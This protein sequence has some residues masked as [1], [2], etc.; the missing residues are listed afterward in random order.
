MKLLI[1]APLLI[2][3]VLSA[4]VPTD[5]LSDE[6]IDY[7]N[8]LHTTWK[9]GRNFNTN[10]PRKF[11]KVING[12][13][14]GANAFQLPKREVSLDVKLPKEFDARTQ[15]PNCP[16][17]S[18]IRDQGSCGS[19]WAFGAVEAMSDRICIHTG[20]NVHL[21]ADNLVSCCSSC[22]FGCSGGFPG[23]AW[24]YWERE[25]IVTG[26]NYGSEKGCQPY[27]IAPCEHHTTGPRPQ[28]SGEGDTPSCKETCQK[29]YKTEYNKDLHYGT[30]SYSIESDVEAIQTEIY[31]N[32]PVEAA[33]TVYEDFVNYKEG[34]YQHVAGGELGGHAI[35]ILGWG[36]E[37]DT[38]YWLVANS[39]NTDWGDKG[40]FKILRGRNECGIE[41]QISAGLP[42]A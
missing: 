10:I 38:P 26:G 21:S 39:W 14:E 30:S 35:K 42:R 4:S 16:T 17:I 37:N 15:W 13:H 6:F 33:F 12:V 19:C 34:V 9:A 22:G 20:K 40:F 29:S 23:A 24:S 32:G 11:L 8:S 41:D 18:E 2:C 7:I 36:V 27:S 5:P 1:L 31:K 3:G 28:C 25:G